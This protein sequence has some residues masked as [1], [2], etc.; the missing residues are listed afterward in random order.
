MAKIKPKFPLLKEPQRASLYQQLGQMAK[1]GLSA[2]KGL[3]TVLTTNPK[4]VKPVSYAKSRMASWGLA[5][6][7][8]MGGLFS[9]FDQYCLQVAEQTGR[10]DHIFFYLADFYQGIVA[11]KRQMRSQMIYPIIILL[12]AFI[13]APLPSLI[14][15]TISTAEYVQ[16]LLFKV[17]V[18]FACLWLFL[19][20]TAI[21]RSGVLP[22]FR[23]L[24]DRLQV[25]LPGVSG[26]YYRRAMFHFFT[27]LHLLYSAGVPVIQAWQQAAGLVPNRAVRQPLLKAYTELNNGASFSDAVMGIPSLDPVLKQFLQTGD[28]SGAIDEMLNHFIQMES[29]QIAQSDKVIAQWIPRILY[30]CVAIWMASN[31]VGSYQAPR[32]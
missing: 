32:Y 13:L 22:G 29:E 27:H 9:N 19:N 7:G 28:E 12:A 23:V 20:I 25:E 8:F 21:A 31:I 3:D 16:S 4:L 30:F 1:A 2:E 11:R 6:A 17:M 18:L 10:Y 14:L 24:V 15:G 26:W 5:R